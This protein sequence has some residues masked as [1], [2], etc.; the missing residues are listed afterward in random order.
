M[1]SGGSLEIGSG[2][3]TI[4]NTYSDT[5]A[6][7]VVHGSYGT[8]YTPGIA[9][10]YASEDSD[11]G[12][13][14][15]MSGQVTVHGGT[16]KNATVS[17]PGGRLTVSSG[18]FTGNV[19]VNP[20]AWFFAGS[21]QA[22]FDGTVTINSDGGA[23]LDGGNY[24]HLKVD[25]GRTLGSFM[26][27]T[28]D[29]FK[30][31]DVYLPHAR[32]EA[33]L[34]AGKDEYITIVRHTQHEYDEKGICSIC[35]T[36]AEAKLY[37]EDG[38]Y[39]KYEYGTIWQMLNK[40]QE[41]QGSCLV[42]LKD[43]TLN[44]DTTISEGNFALSLGRWHLRCADSQNEIALVI[45]GGEISIKDGTFDRLKV[46]DKG[47][48]TL[49]GGK[50][51]A[52]DVTDS[53]YENYGQL[54]PDGYAFK[55][56]SGW[57]AKSSI[58]DKSFDVTRTNAPKSVEK[59]PFDSVSVAPAITTANY[60]KPMT[61]TATVTRD[62][63]S[64]ALSYQW[65]TVAINGTK[66]AI[67]GATGATLTVNEAVGTYQYLCQVTCEDYTLSSNTVQLTV[68]WID[69]S[70]AALSAT[71]QT[72][73][74][75]GTTNATVTSS[76]IGS[77]GLRANTDYTISSAEFEDK[78][79]G[80]GK[81]VTV[82]VTL[83]N[84]NYCFGYDANKHPIMEKTFQATGTITK[85][86]SHMEQTKTVDAYSGVAH[87]YTVD[88]DACLS[89]LQNLGIE[90]YQIT[91][92]DIVVS[93]LIDANQVVLEG[94]SL[95]IPVN[96]VVTAPGTVAAKFTIAVACKNYSNV[97]ILV[98]VETKDRLAVT[99]TATPSKSKLTYGEK[100]D[101]ITLSGETIPELQG[102]FAW[103]RPDA[104]LDAGTYT[105]LGWKFTPDN[106]TYAEASGMAKI[107][108]KQAKLQ[109]PAPMTLTIYNGWAATYEAA[110]PELPTLAEGLHF[111]NDNDAAYG[112]PGR[113]GRPGT[114]APARS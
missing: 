45:N 12:N 101:T 32:N 19:I 13:L 77:S 33:E 87:T 67:E 113:L 68:Q 73:A 92:K 105:E 104:I 103:Q 10:I 8:Y 56:S 30:M 61:F 62:D 66:T 4:Q 100:L 16:F 108:V 39:N 88:L 74:Y 84:L 76:S 55:T 85:N 93:K 15:I 40:A 95:K 89:K 78:N 48:L 70:D 60:G 20:N 29:M 22:Y 28:L 79:A 18:R 11:L 46:T 9:T 82:K 91:E 80:E 27:N 36:Q 50:Y 63:S 81:K 7:I 71:I 106:Y 75:D 21:S 111:G 1:Q 110:L 49:N 64:K 3:Y 99:A 47:K 58:T 53:T 6:S 24:K 57:E 86:T 44:S 65:Y 41:T 51:Y 90:G 72:R 96:A 83:T 102:T 5:A 98:R 17:S 59:P 42:L 97:T 94:H 34:T 38:N 26:P 23:T 43:I 114:I 2:K 112:T 37:P 25:G 35:N 31:G 107:T 14:L 109:D 69:L 52:I 54:L